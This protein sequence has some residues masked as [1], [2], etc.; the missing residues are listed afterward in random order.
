MNKVIFL[1]LIALGIGLSVPAS[2][3]SQNHRPPGASANAMHDDG[4]RPNEVRRSTDTSEPP[5]MAYQT[6]GWE[7]SND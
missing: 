3:G 7:E 2:A 4:A 5:Y 6:R 1:S